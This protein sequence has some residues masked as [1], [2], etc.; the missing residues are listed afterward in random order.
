MTDI[1]EASP[2]D[3]PALCALLD[4][5]FTQEAEFR[6][7]AHRQARGLGQ[8]VASPEAG[9]ILVLREDGQISGMVCLLF[10]ISTALGGRVALLEDMVLR[11]ASRG[12]GLGTNL[13][14]A[15]LALARRSGCLRV[16]LLTDS[17]NEV[18]QRFY[19]K[20]GFSTS[21]MTAMRLLFEA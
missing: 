10:T 2:A 4:L 18:A 14:Q 11:P 16:T 5:L 19:K 15:A 1:D 7:D 13:A 21:G 3:I 17:D 6:P 8:I 12:R 9:R 20:L